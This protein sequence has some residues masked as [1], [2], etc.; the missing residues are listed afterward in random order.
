[1][2]GRRC[3]LHAGHDDARPVAAD[4][5]VC[6]AEAAKKAGGKLTVTKHICST[7]T[8]V[9]EIDCEIYEGGVYDLHHEGR[10]LSSEEMAAFWADLA[11]R[12]PIVSIEDGMDEEDWDGWKALTDRIGERVQLVG[13]DLFVTN[14]ERLR[15]GIERGVANSILVKVNQIGTL[16]ET[17]EDCH[18][19]HVADASLLEHATHFGPFEIDTDVPCRCRAGRGGRDVQCRHRQSP[20]TCR[21]RDRTR[22]PRAIRPGLEGDA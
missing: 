17:I 4:V 8:F 5:E 16:T 14:T 3:H 2:A 12:Y 18:R 19:R 9:S 13:D 6:L 22:H 21:R 7:E 20:A 10:K 11:E 1:M 15:R